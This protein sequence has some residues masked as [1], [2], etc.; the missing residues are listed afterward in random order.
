MNLLKDIKKLTTQQLLLL[1]GI[2]LV[3]L[4]LTNYSSRLGSLFSGM[5]GNSGNNGES[6]NSDANNLQASSVVA[7]MPAGLNSGPGSANG[8]SGL[9]TSNGGF[10]NCANKLATNP[11]DLL[12]KNNQPD[13]L[14]AKNSG[15]LENT[16]FLK[17]GFHS[18]I[19]TIGS[20]LRNANLQLR[21]EPP[22]PK[23]S[24]LGPWNHSTIESDTMRP[25]FELGCGQ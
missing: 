18:G 16:S 1:A 6:N 7:A 5:K 17:A 13:A 23:S 11:S 2:V 8:S 22:N 21:S 25:G 12:P 20:S 10:N 24:N 4:Y 14:N 15:E 19:D 9:I 3:V